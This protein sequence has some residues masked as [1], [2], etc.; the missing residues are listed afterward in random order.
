MEKLGGRVLLVEDDVLVRMALVIAFNESGIEVIEAGN[1]DDAIQM[2]QAVPGIR[3]VVTDVDMPGSMNG[4]GL[5]REVGQRWPEMHI[6]II[7]GL[8]L[9]T[10]YRTLTNVAVL[11]KPFSPERLV[12]V[13]R[14]ALGT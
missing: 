5:V 13:V 12:D 8:P 4:L 7:S 1:A 10:G 6:L 3:V 2:L 14:R 9:P 11:Q